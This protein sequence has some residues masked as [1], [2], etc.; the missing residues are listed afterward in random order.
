M[1]EAKASKSVSRQHTKKEMHY[2]AQFMKTYRNKLSRVEKHPSGIT[3]AAYSAKF[4]PIA[5]AR[6]TPKR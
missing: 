4:Y 3:P 2:R 5:L 1:A 6:S